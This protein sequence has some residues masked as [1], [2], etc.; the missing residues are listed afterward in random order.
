MINLL[1]NKLMTISL[2]CPLQSMPIG[3]QASEPWL[4]I[5]TV[6]IWNGI[7]T[8]VLLLLIIHV[9]S[10]RH[11]RSEVESKYAEDRPEKSNS[12]QSR[13]SNVNNLHDANRESGQLSEQDVLSIDKTEIDKRLKEIEMPAPLPENEIS[14][15]EISNPSPDAQNVEVQANPEKVEDEVVIYVQEREE[16]YLFSETEEVDTYNTSYKIKVK[17]NGIDGSF[18]VC[19]NADVIS[20]LLSFRQDTLL[21]CVKSYHLEGSIKS[22]RTIAPG[23][24]HKEG[25]RW[26]V[27]KEAHIEYY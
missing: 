27:T 8:V 2:T 16:G 22:I 14:T 11:N 21:N 3:G 24:V 5:N 10:S 13:Q 1:L 23:E 19:D 18:Y 25:N 4:S 12:N 9:L 15:Q 6:I 7:L 20:R 26:I 17:P